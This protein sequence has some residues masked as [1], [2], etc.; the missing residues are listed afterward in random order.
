MSSSVQDS[1]IFSLFSHI[2]RYATQVTDM[3][4]MS[5]IIFNINIFELKT[6]GKKKKCKMKKLHSQSVT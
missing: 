4:R 3:N 1:S 6:V 2:Y 5:A